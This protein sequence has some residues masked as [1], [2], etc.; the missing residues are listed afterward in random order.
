MTPPGLSFIA[1]NDRALEAHRSANLRTSYWDWTQREGPLHYQKYCG[2]P[3]EHLLFGLRKALDM[4]FAEGLENVFERHRLI[5]EA[6]RCAVDAWSDGG[7]LSFNVREPAERA[8]SVTHVRTEGFDPARL[9]AYCREKCGVVLGIGIGDFTDRAF[10]IAHMGHINA[11]MIMGTLSTVEIGLAALG[12]AHGR[13]G[14]QA[15]I[16]WLS[17]NVKP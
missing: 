9:L 7:A 14:A 1:A 11:P 8:D 12:I 17:D 4:L 15:A 10:R 6:V 13:G 3:P 16:D 2:T 5:A